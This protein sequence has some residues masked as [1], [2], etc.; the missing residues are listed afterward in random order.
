MPVILLIDL[1]ALRHTGVG[2]VGSIGP[3]S[4]LTEQVSRA[5]HPLGPECIRSVLEVYL[6]SRLPRMGHPLGPGGSALEVYLPSRKCTYQVGCLG[7]ATLWAQVAG[8]TPVAL[9]VYT[10]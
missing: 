1:W 7:W 9:T 2:P 10:E 8:C 5:G 3:G 4:I 6:L